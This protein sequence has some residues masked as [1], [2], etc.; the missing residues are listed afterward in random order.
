MRFRTNFLHRAVGYVIDSA[1]PHRI[2]FASLSPCARLSRA[3]DD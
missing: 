1:N 3:F 2:K